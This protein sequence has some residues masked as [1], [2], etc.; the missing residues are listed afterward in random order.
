MPTVVAR[1]RGTDQSPQFT[2][3]RPIVDL[4]DLLYKQLSVDKVYFVETVKGVDGSYTQQL[5]EAG[6][7]IIQFL[8]SGEKVTP[9]VAAVSPAVKP[10]VADR[11]LASPESRNDPI[12]NDK[13]QAIGLA[14]PT[15]NNRNLT[16]S[17]SSKRK[18][19]KTL[20]RKRVLV[21]PTPPPPVLPKE[22]EFVFSEVSGP[23]NAHTRHKTQV[24]LLAEKGI[25]ETPVNTRLPKSKTLKGP[26]F[27]P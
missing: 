17:R 10:P 14:T 25:V 21:R 6:A 11:P 7:F 3:P 26:M 12:A 19:P 15:R 1:L 20:R 5:T 22:P 9:P 27:N 4:I 18:R 23:L 16:P 24:Q 2:Q 13:T 8:P